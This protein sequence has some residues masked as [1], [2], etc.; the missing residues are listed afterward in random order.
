MLKM[1]EFVNLQDGSMKDEEMRY[2]LNQD[3]S[4]YGK[5]CY[6]ASTGCFILFCMRQR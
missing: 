2:C 4:V 1:R 6:T 3:E 5:K